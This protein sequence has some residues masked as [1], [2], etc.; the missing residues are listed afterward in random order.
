MVIINCVVLYYKSGRKGDEYIQKDTARVLVDD[1]SDDISTLHKLKKHLIGFIGLENIA[2]NIGL[3]ENVDVKLCR[4]EK[5][6]GKGTTAYTIQTDAQLKLEM[7]LILTA[8]HTLQ[9]TA[10]QR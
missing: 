2:N 9:I 1:V 4:L 5:S 6:G 10:S 3:G 8:D 7:P